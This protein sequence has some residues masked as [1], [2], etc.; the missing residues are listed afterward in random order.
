MHRERERERETAHSC[1]PPKK[2][3]DFSREPPACFPCSGCPQHLIDEGF[4]LAAWIIDA[5][6]ADDTEPFN[7]KLLWNPPKLDSDMT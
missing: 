1:P 7:T 3:T 2:Q 5:G 4:F 6:T